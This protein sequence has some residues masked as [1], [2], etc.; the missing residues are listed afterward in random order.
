MQKSAPK[1]AKSTSINGHTWIDALHLA[2]EV[3]GF[4][5]RYLATVKADI[6]VAVTFSVTKSLYSAY[7]GMFDKVIATLRVFRQQNTNLAKLNLK[8]GKGSGSSD[9]FEDTTFVSDDEAFDIGAAQSKKKK[10]EGGGSEDLI[11]F[12][13]IGAVIAFVLFKLKKK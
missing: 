2:S 9:N 5:T 12:G 6:G 8:R 10:S 13:V 3:P 11:I 4:Y 1:Y 7:Q